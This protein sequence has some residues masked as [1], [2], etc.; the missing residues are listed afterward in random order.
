MSSICVRFLA[1]WYHTMQATLLLVGHLT[2][3]LVPKYSGEQ[4]SSCPPL[5]TQQGIPWPRTRTSAGV[6]SIDCLISISDL[7][8][9][10]TTCESSSTSFRIRQLSKNPTTVKSPVPWFS[11]PNKWS[12]FRY[13]TAVSIQPKV[14]NLVNLSNHCLIQL[15]KT[16]NRGMWYVSNLSTPIIRWPILQI[17]SNL[18]SRGLNFRLPT[19]TNMGL[20]MVLGAAQLSPGAWTVR[21]P[22]QNLRSP[23][24]V[25]SQWWT[26][27]QTPD[28]WL[29]DMNAGWSK[30]RDP[31]KI[32]EKW[33]SSC[34]IQMFRFFHGRKPIPD[35]H[36]AQT[37]Q[38]CAVSEI[39]TLGSRFGWK[40]RI[41][42]SFSS[43]LEL[44]VLCRS[45]HKK[46][47]SEVKSC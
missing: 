35:S 5:Q 27:Q 10:G 11:P 37:F 43:T 8:L 2:A 23:W 46:C 24:D 40:N 4:R 47:W 41:T 44:S 25:S 18:W 22:D 20:G 32:W 26:P 7:I 9:G 13:W 33:T 42:S 12:G 21:H 36:D 31:R 39:Q 38:S 19:A 6:A 17:D 28:H 16:K 45:A 29:Q 1:R 3:F 14:T 15:R 34:S 30:I